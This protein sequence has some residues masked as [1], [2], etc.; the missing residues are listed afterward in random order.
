MYCYR[1]FPLCWGCYHSTTLE[2]V[3][4]NSIL[5]MQNFVLK[6]KD[7][8]PVTHTESVNEQT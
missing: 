1:A 5:Q 6:P 3:K 8:I 4:Q 2:I 7:L